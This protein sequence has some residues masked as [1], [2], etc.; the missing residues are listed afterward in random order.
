MKFLNIKSFS[1]EQAGFTLIE[2]M[3]AMV[4]TGFISLGAT[5]ASSQVLTQT[6]KNTDYTI[7]NRNTM[8]ALHWISRD[9]MMAQ[10]MDGVEDFPQNGNLSLSW[11]EWDTTAH[12]ANYSLEDGNLLR[13]YSDNGQVTKTL[14][15]E[16]I[17]PDANSTYCSS[18]NGVL[19]V[20]I[21]SRVGEGSRV[22]DVKRVKEIALR[23]KL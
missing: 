11:V 13:I 17:N 6:S 21:S 18:D 4:I 9:A 20:T 7:A 19:I 8:N 10:T 15:A 22:V 16:Y 12:T 23:P 14:I 3:V 1:K 5:I 2:L